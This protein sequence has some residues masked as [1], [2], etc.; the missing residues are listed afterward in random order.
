MINKYLIAPCLLVIDE[1]NFKF[2]GASRNR[3]KEFADLE[4]SEANLSHML[5]GHFGRMAN[6]NYQ[7]RD[8]VIKQKDF[9]IE[10]KYLRNFATSF[11]T[12]SNKMPWKDAFQKD[13]NWLC[14]ELNK[15]YKGK[16][17]FVLGWFNIGAFNTLM[18][19][20][21][22]KGQTPDF[23][24]EKTRLLP[25]INAGK[26][27]TSQVYYNYKF[28]YEPLPVFPLTPL[29]SSSG[30]DCIFLGCETDKFHFA[31]YY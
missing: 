15:G 27:K 26:N 28:A 17:A 20:G 4:F 9:M 6:Y 3:I 18:Q 23:D 8:L 2:E 10:F 29:K 13:Y 21:T 22:G 24:L 16:R 12:R 1:F 31:I 5:G 19:I 11:N 30:I 14:G 25:F 7:N